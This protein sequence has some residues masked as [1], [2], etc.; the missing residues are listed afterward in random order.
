MVFQLT[1][2]KPMLPSIDH[3]VYQDGNLYD[4]DRKLGY[5]D[6]SS[7]YFKAKIKGRSFLLHRL[8]Y[9]FHHGTLPKML[10]HEDRNKLNNRIENLRPCEYRGNNTVNSE[11][12]S[13]NTSGYRGVAWHKASGK[14]N[15]SVSY[16][17]KRYH[18]GLFTDRHEAAH[19][20]N[21]K[22]LELFGNFAKLNEVNND[23]DA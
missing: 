4:G 23:N 9:L 6:K 8:I 20:Y 18:I 14:W 1:M 10:D 22:A 11:I 15:C 13:D 5:Y 19:E 2:V 12:R 7:K 16:K 3:L 21:K 17:G